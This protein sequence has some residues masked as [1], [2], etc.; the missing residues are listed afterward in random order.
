MDVHINKPWLVPDALV[1]ID[2]PVAQ[3]PEFDL[4]ML[5]ENAIEMYVRRYGSIRSFQRVRT[6]EDVYI[7][8]PSVYTGR[9]GWMP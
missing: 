6:R 1:P 9:D 7:Q 8:H 4:S 2:P 3:P 5:N